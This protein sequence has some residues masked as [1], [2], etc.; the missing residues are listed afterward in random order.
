MHGE[1][2]ARQW[3]AAAVARENASRQLVSYGATYWQTG[4]HAPLGMVGSLMASRQAQMGPQFPRICFLRHAHAADC[5]RVRAGE[6]YKGVGT[7]SRELGSGALA[8]AAVARTVARMTTIVAVAAISKQYYCS[9]S[10]GGIKQP[11]DALRSGATW[12][13]P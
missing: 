7:L 2:S 6:P 8:T 10:D 12:Q 3:S 5:W 4:R 9:G 11:S 13:Y 1:V